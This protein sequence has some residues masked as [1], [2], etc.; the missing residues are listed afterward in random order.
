MNHFFNIDA[1][2]LVGVDCKQQMAD[3]SV[4]EVPLVAELHVV[5][6]RGLERNRYKQAYCNRKLAVKWTRCA[7]RAG[8]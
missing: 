5:Q 3:I 8:G 1:E 7:P 2:R 6:Q 4:N